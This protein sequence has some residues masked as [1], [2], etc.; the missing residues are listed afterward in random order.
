MLLRVTFSARHA[1]KRARRP[2]AH[3]LLAAAGHFDQVHRHR[4]A[5]GQ[6]G[7]RWHSCADGAPAGTHR[8]AR[9][10]V[11]ARPDG[12]LRRGAALWRRHDHAGDHRP[13][14]GR[15]T[16]GRDTAVRVV[17]RAGG[18][19]DP[20]RGVRDS[21][22]WHA[23]CR[24]IL[25][26]DHG[27]VVCGDCAARHRVAGARAGRPDGHRSSPRGFILPRARVARV[28]RPRRSLSGRHRR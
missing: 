8:L 9:A 18:G 15:G 25:R 13:W 17:R 14:R 23:P 4:H 12:H 2:V 1:R 3:H 10:L 19:R 11:G 26:A 6:R 16:Q 5:R 24:A 28:C 21:E 22:A 7:R 20:D 27:R